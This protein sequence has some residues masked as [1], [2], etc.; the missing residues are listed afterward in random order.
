MWLLLAC[1]G[2][3]RYMPKDPEKKSIRIQWNKV[4]F[5]VA[6]VKRLDHL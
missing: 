6:Q 5:D 2:D 3:V 4:V 1:T